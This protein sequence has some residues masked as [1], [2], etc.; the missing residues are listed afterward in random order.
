MRRRAPNSARST[1]ISE[2]PCSSTA[3]P[4]SPSRGVPASVSPRSPSPMARTLMTGV[5]GAPC[6]C[7]NSTKRPTRTPLQSPCGPYWPTATKPS[8]S[9][10][11]PFGPGRCHLGRAPRLARL[12]PRRCSHRGGTTPADRAPLPV[13]RTAAYPDP[14]RLLNSKVRPH[15]PPHRRLLLRAPLAG[16]CPRGSREGLHLPLLRVGFARALLAANC[17]CDMAQAL[18]R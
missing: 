12:Q 4:C 13:P 1:P 16:Q 8:S 14:A 9:P 6:S 10:S 2:I 3:M 5:S 11:A 7:G 17:P 15:A 18:A